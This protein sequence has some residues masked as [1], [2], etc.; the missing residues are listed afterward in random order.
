MRANEEDILN[1]CSNAKDEEEN[2]QTGESSRATATTQV[3]GGDNSYDS[4][5]T[6][7]EHGDWVLEGWVWSDDEKEVCPEYGWD[8]VAEVH[9]GPGG[10]MSPYEATTMLAGT[11]SRPGAA[12][13]E[14]N[15]VRNPRRSL[16]VMY[17]NQRKSERLTKRKEEGK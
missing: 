8:F 5:R 1:R 2:M 11:T 6:L 9:L 17:K 16:R 3:P 14:R 7:S 12:V 10:T 13:R 4:D 15:Y